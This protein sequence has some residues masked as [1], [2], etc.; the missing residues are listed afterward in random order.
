[1]E[2]GTYARALSVG[3]NEE[4]SGF[5]A[6]FGAEIKDEAV[7]RV[8][9]DAKLKAEEAPWLARVLRALADKIDN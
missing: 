1:M 3:F 9:R 4:Q 8:Q 2:G 5:L 6:R 7:E